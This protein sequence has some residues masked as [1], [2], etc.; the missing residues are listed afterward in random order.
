MV[1]SE[2]ILFV[3]CPTY[4]T[5]EADFKPEKSAADH[6]SEKVLNCL[7]GQ[8]KTYPNVYFTGLGERT[9]KRNVSAGI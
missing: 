2:A 3:I 5:D 9:I 4:Y 7:D 1:E 8:V 6:M